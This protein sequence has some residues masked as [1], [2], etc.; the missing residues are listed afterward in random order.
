VTRGAYYTTSGKTPQLTGVVSDVVAPGPLAELDIGE[1]YAKYPLEPDSIPPSFEDDLSDIPFI[2]R[3]Q[4]RRA[5][6]F[7]LQQPTT[8]YTRHIPILRA[9]SK[10]RIDANGEY[11]EFLNTKAEPTAERDPDQTDFQM[12]ECV[13]IMKD[14]ILLQER[15]Q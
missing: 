8:M 3:A 9:K 1:R 14:L 5:Y 7:D 11:Q 2:H 6:L 10:G 13:N 4:A 15:S 12:V